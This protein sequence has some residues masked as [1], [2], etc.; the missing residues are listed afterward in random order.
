MT[1][2]TGLKDY[3]RLIGGPGASCYSMLGKIGGVQS[4]SLGERN[5]KCARTCIIE[6]V[7]VHEFL[8]SFGLGHVQ[9]RPDRDQ[10]IEVQSDNI[11]FKSQYEIIED[12]LIFDVPY[13]GRSTMHYAWKAFAIDQMRPTMLSKVEFLF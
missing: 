4:L 12:A 8:H 13:D 1:D 7:I 11:S 9:S 10:Y 5:E 3:V 2:T 6:H